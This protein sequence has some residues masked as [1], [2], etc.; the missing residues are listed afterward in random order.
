VNPR[1]VPMDDPNRPAP[2]APVAPAG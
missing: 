2:Q 1:D